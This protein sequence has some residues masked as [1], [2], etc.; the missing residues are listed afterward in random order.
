MVMIVAAKCPV[1]NELLAHETVG[2]KKEKDGRKYQEMKCSVCGTTNQ[3]FT[4]ENGEDFQKNYD[5][6]DNTDPSDTE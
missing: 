6:P 5:Y 4:G 3:V 2:E 1:C